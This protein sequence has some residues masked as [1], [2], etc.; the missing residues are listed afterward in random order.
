M[1]AF[2]RDIRATSLYREAELL[3]KALRQP[4]TGQISDATEVCAAPDGTRAV[5]VGSQVDKLEGSPVTRICQL[6]LTSG[7]TRVVTFGPNTDRLPKYSPD[8]LSVAF[9]SDRCKSGDFQLYLLCPATGAVRPTPS[10]DGW[11]EYL[12]WSPD[13]ARILL[14]VAGHGAVISGAQGAASS[15]PRTDDLPSWIPAV[16]AGGERHHWRRAW[17]YELATNHVRPVGQADCN[18]W[19][20]AWCGDDA[21]AAVASP[22]PGEGLWYGATLRI[23]EIGSGRSREV[24]LP[25]YQLGCLAAPRSGNILAIVEAISSDRWL[26]AGDLLLIDPATGKAHKIDTQAVDVSYTQW[27]SD[28]RLLVAGHRG[29]ATVIAVYDAPSRTFNDIW[30]SRDVTASGFYATVSGLNER[31]DCVLVGEGFL[32]APEI[33]LIRNGEYQSVRSFD[34]NHGDEASAIGSVHSVSWNAPDGL[35]IQGWLLRPK[36]DGPY[37]LV[38]NVHGGPVWQWRP[39]WLGRR[40]V[41]LLLLLKRGF[42]V[43]FPNPRGSAGWG[44]EFAELVVGDMGGADTDDCLSGLDH[45]V[46]QGIADRQRLG[47]TGISYGGFMTTWMITQ[48][49]RFAAAVAVAPA[50]NHVTAHLLSNI[51]QFVALFLADTYT[52]CT[53]KYFSRSPIMHAQKARTPTLLVCGALDRCTPPEEAAQFHS[54]LLANG[55][56]SVLVNYP[57]EGHGVRK[58]PAAIDYAARV[59]GWFEEHM[60]STRKSTPAT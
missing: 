40:F 22:G 23:I 25:R 39:I 36:G 31:G 2:E 20:A 58:W 8:G 47:I 19:E 37:P 41:H 7:D 18:I 56:R 55:V 10:V 26:V 9:L 54:A 5:Y 1:G 42:A 29:P 48:D 52:N 34:L 57:E 32:R 33:A 59:V 17:V 21:I 12:H 4:I 11:V 46:A 16:D 28:R 13:G 45:L 6:D 38:M 35:D 15:S 14:G 51:P 60:G 43:F 24:L 3:Y 27:L 49:S 53:G 30:S 44:H 50:T